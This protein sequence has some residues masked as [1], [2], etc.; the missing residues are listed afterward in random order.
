MVLSQTG[1]SEASAQI[2]TTMQIHIGHIIRNEL[3]HSGHTNQWLTAQISIPH[4]LY[5]NS[6]TNPQST[7]SNFTPSAASS[8]PAIPRVSKKI[9]II[10]T[11]DGLN[12]HSWI[13]TDKGLAYF[14]LLRRIPYKLVCFHPTITFLNVVNLLLLCGTP[15]I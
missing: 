1:D 5:K 10:L 12:F 14:C 13:C 7:P 2:A 8:S 9:H 15:K 11:S 4:A 6:S 3:R